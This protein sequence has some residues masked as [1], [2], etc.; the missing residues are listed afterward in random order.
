MA[1]SRTKIPERLAKKK[2]PNSDV[3]KRQVETT[4]NDV[5][6]YDVAEEPLTNSTADEEETLDVYKRQDHGS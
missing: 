2:W 5:D 3:Y 1:N 4:E 6:S